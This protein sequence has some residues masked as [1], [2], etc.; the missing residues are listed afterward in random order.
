MDS[1]FLQQKSRPHNPNAFLYRKS[2]LE[3]RILID[4]SVDCS[5]CNA[6]QSQLMQILQKME[7]SCSAVG[8]VC[9]QSVAIVSVSAGVIRDGKVEFLVVFECTVVLPAIHD[10]IEC[11]VISISKGGIRSVVEY[12]G[13]ISVTA[14]IYR[15]VCLQQNQMKHFNDIKVGDIIRVE[16]LAVQCRL[17]SQFITVTASISAAAVADVVK[18]K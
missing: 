10:K 11:R 8:F 16:V 6:V 13:E 14:Y 9:H 15:D 17:H 7:G 18:I 12:M 2:V 4:P 1:L 5:D 3:A